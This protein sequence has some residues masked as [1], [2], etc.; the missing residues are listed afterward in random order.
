MKTINYI[1]EGFGFKNW[2]DFKVSTFGFIQ[3]LTISVAT[4]TG[5]IVSFV[6]HFFGFSYW[7]LIGYVVLIGGEW[8]TGVLASRKR[9]EKH[10]SRKLGRMLLKIGVYS[11]IIFIP[12]TFQRES[13]F[14]VAF[15]Y[16]LDPFIWLYWIVILVIIWQLFISVLENLEQLKFRFA[17]VLLKVIN[18]KFYENLG[19]TNEKSNS[20]T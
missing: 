18:K 16:E 10:E 1:L 2:L 12:N 4:I 7:F 5:A 6:E 11:F 15:G 19:V 8:T 9:K 13:Q 14:P 20:I 17:G 3:P